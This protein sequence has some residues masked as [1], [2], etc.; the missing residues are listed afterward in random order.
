[1]TSSVENDPQVEKEEMIQDDGAGKRSPAA[2]AVSYILFV[3]MLVALDQWTKHLAVLHLKE[4]PAVSLIKGALELRYLENNGA[5]FSILQG[6]QP[7]FFVLTAVFLALFI[8]F[9]WRVPKTKK[10][11]PLIMCMLF[12][13][14]GAVGNLIDRAAHSYVVD[15]IY[16]SLIDFPIFN[17]ADIYVTLS[18]IALV[19]LL[20]F[21]YKESDMK[22]LHR[23]KDA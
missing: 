13:S 10:Y 16:I 23:R 11:L 4:Q 8:W 21:R 5:A 15:F 7:V 22:F 1:M 2:R 20:M 12:L 19:L 18:V 6:R 9:C 17:V 14:G 3:V